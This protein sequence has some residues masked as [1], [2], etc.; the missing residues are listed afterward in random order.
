MRPQPHPTVIG[1]KLRLR[2]T[3]R[4]PLPR[5]RP[6]PDPHPEPRRGITLGLIA[7]MPALELRLLTA[8]QSGKSPSQPGHTFGHCR[9]IAI[10]EHV[11]I[12]GAIGIPALCL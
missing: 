1:R 12:P 11:V 10:V 2:R 3:D 6:N 8:G 4:H 9:S 5:Q 7:G